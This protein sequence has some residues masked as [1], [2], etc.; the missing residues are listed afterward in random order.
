MP[1]TLGLFVLLLCVASFVRADESLLLATGK[2]ADRPQQPQVVVDG[3]GVAHVVYG[4]GNVVLYRRSED[5]GKS[6][7]EPVVIETG[8]VLALGMR[9][10]PRV[11]VAGKND[12]I[13]AICVAAIG[14]AQGK[15]RDG[16]LLTF[17]SVDAGKTWSPAVVVN[18][19]AGS[20]REGLHALAAG[21]RGVFCAVWLDL[22][23]KRTELYAAT[24]VDAGKT[25]GPNTLVYRSPD[26]SICQ[27]CHPSVA[28]DDAGRI[29]V[30]WRNS[31]EGERDMYLAASTDGGRT[32]DAAR[33]LG[34][35]RWPLDACP[36]DGG[37]LAFLPSANGTPG[38]ALTV[39]RRDKNVFAF[40]EEDRTERELGPGEQ[41]WL[42]VAGDRP[43]VAWVRKR[44][45]SLRVAVGDR[46]D[47][48]W[49]AK[50]F[51]PVVAAAPHTAT[52]AAP[53]AAAKPV[54]AAV[55]WEER[56]GDTTT[57]RYRFLE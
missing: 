32:F 29:A 14:G 5:G 17:R 56:T 21:P 4:V 24:S 1:R 31:L 44:G 35:G 7:A 28:I 57:I 15:G 18:D 55:V 6:F 39:W 47:V 8:R 2:G 38:G 13:T 54:A 20:A 3:G 33:K 51:D 11:A 49:A 53:G 22:R 25:W 43:I 34:T 40:A 26:G 36:M 52:A 48:E 42:A 27:C 30:L 19:V 16:D 10:G 9:R 37:A 46:P 50:A 23:E 12:G 41:P 45:G